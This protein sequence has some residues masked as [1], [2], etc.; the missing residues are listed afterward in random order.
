MPT[1]KILVN[2]EEREALPG[3]S[4]SEFVVTL[5]FDPETV[6]VELDGQILKQADYAEHRLANGSEL[7]LIRFVG[8]G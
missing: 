4:V 6:V 3:V 8:G 5:G 7:E 1:M 2:G